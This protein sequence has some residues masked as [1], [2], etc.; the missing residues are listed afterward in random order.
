MAELENGITTG[1]ILKI[2]RIAN[3]MKSSEVAITL[4]VSQSLLS[5][6]EGGTKKVSFK[7]LDK[8]ASVYNAK[9]SKIIGFVEEAKENSLSY[10]EI[11]KMVLEYYVLEN[12][13]TRTENEAFIKMYKKGTF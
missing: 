11:L 9:P 1:K 8:F 6:I 12:P 4:E 13:K 10:P 2:I 7:M 3:D 5:Q